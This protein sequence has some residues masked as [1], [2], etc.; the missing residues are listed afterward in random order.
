M[1]QKEPQQIARIAFLAA[2]KGLAGIL[3]IPAGIAVLAGQP[4]VGVT[5]LIPATLVLEY[6]ATPVGITLGMNPACVL[7]ISTSI[8]LGAT[9][10]LLD[11]FDLAGQHSAWLSGLLAKAR[12]RT[13]RSLALSRYGKFA[14]VPLVLTLGIY[15]C[16][17]VAWI[18]GWPRRQSIVLITT[19][20]S[21][22]A[23]AMILISMGIIRLVIP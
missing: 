12:E 13:D 14:L 17:P 3:V 1:E 6:G 16:A 7:A 4:F 2:V 5:A 11:L 20:Y 18:M 8:C 22:G 21:V 23:T 15:I 10:L 9:S 19:G